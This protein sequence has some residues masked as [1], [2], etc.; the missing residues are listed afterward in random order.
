VLRLPWRNQAAVWLAP[1]TVGVALRGRGWRAPPAQYHQA[2][3]DGGANAPAAALSAFSTLAA[4]ARTTKA[5]T[6]IVVSNRFVRTAL[7]PGAQGLRGSA[8]RQ[9]AAREVLRATHGDSVDTWALA[10]DDHGAAS[11]L[12]AGLDA[13]WLASLLATAQQAGWQAVSVRPL[14]ALAAAQV[15]PHVAGREVWLLVT[16]PDGAVLAHINAQG[17]W[18]SLRSLALGS[19]EQAANT[20]PPWLARCCLLEGVEPGSLPLVHAAWAWAAA[21]P[22]ESEANAAL[23]EAGWTP[24]TVSIG[25]D[26]LWAPA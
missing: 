8:E 25:P 22:A 14:L 11:P 18:L 19:Q 1:S 24:Q 4:Q 13:D 9:L 20:L 21:K 6:R 3:I 10:V 5:H 16:E 7:L 26:T 12:A 2:F 15:W 23:I 17:A